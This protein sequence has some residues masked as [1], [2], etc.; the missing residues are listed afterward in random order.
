ML[1]EQNLR[2]LLAERAPWF[3][4]RTEEINWRLV[5]RFERR[6]AQ[7]FGAGRVWLAGDA[8]HTTGPV[9]MQSMNV[10]LREAHDLAA[11]FAGILRSGESLDGLD[12]YQRARQAEW[13][14]LLGMEGI[15][16]ARDQA[17]PWIAQRRDR[18]PMCLPASGMRLTELVQQLGLEWA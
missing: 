2:R 12:R 8:G 1:D 11:M 14:T 18:L 9:G 13:R 17:N 5:V 16:T 6:L 10:G 3:G 4:G 15:P 7:R